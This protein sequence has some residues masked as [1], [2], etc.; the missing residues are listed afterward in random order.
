MISYSSISKNEEATRA[1]LRELVERLEVERRLV[2]VPE[3]LRYCIF[4]MLINCFAVIPTAIIVAKL[5][6][7][8]EKGSMEEFEFIYI[9]AAFL[10]GVFSLGAA[11]MSIGGRIYMVKVLR[12]S[13][14]S[15]LILTF[16]CTVAVLLNLST[17]HLG[18]CL[19][20]LL[21]LGLGYWALNTMG[22]YMFASFY[23]GR[24]DLKQLYKE[25]KKLFETTDKTVAQVSEE[26]GV[27][28][29]LI[30]QW[31]AVI[32]MQSKQKRRKS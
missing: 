23:A 19:A 31:K 14:L 15:L 25:S 6:N 10:G 1:V 18:V 9:V 12:A 24:Q 8:S 3:G 20:G 17:I 30:T 26:L 32:D 16:V 7:I 29:D 21:S 13:Y 28:A 22:F 5:V 4:F 2:F 27:R 11:H